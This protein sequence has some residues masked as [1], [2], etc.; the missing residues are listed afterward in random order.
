[1]CLTTP[2]A[3]INHAYQHCIATAALFPDNSMQIVLQYGA[4][5][6]ATNQG[7]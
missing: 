7:K 5:C 6:M 3:T 4:D 2:T 1:M